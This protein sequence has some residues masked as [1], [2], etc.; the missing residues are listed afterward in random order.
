MRPAAALLVLTL[1]AAPAGAVL[2]EPDGDPDVAE[3]RQAIDTGRYALG[4]DLLQAALARLPGDPDLLVYVAFAHRRSGRAEAA[5][6]AYGEA[7]ARDPTH[8]G[9]LAYQGGLYIELGRRADAEANL[10]RLRAACPGCAETETL[11]R[12]LA[13]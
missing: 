1:L 9:A 3:A 8:P 13:R 10:A 6:A 4:L 5:L 11:A 2:P 12:D 7:L